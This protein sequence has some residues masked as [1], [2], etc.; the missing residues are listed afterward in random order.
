MVPSRVK[1]S[2]INS[3]KENLTLIRVIKPLN[4]C[5]YWWLTAA[6]SATKRN[7][8]VFFTVNLKTDTF[9][10]LHIFLRWV[11]E[12]NIAQLNISINL[13]FLN[14]N[15]ASSVNLRRLTQNFY[16]F[17]TGTKDIHGIAKHIW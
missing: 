15:T 13:I 4:H 1:L 7:N 8:S 9:K 17:V 5:N 3:I 11:S 10:N 6:G 2:D 12:F 14:C 16:N